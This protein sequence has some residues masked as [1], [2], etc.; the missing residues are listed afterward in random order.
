MGL[1]ELRNL[2][3]RHARE[4]VWLTCA[5]LLLPN[6]QS[7]LQRVKNAE[8]TARELFPLLSHKLQPTVSLIGPFILINF[9]AIHILHRLRLLIVDAIQ[10]EKCFRRSRLRFGIPDQPLM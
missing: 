2:L 7:L 1:V 3:R 5:L 10:D 6:L 8:E 4:E 9:H